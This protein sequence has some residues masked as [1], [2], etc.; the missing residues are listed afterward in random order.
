MA[1]DRV[2]AQCH[3]R[4]PASDFPPVRRKGAQGELSKLCALCMKKDAERKKR[5]RQMQKETEAEE[6]SETEKEDPAADLDPISL[7]DFLEALSQVSD[8]PF[9]IGARVRA[10]EAG[11]LSADPGDR[12]RKLVE[13][14]GYNKQLHWT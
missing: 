7:P 5:K 14:L 12:A 1:E 4:K 9:D 8:G 6:E 3:A 2:C 11:L 13:I 10:P